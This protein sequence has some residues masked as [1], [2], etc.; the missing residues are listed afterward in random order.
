[1]TP[2]PGPFLMQL[3]EAMTA[4]RPSVASISVIKSGFCTSCSNSRPW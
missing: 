3:N 4:P 1:M 2:A